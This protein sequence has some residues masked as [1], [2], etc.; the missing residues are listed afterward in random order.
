MHVQGSNS[1]QVVHL[2]YQTPSNSVVIVEDDGTTSSYS[3]Q[4]NVAVK[5]VSPKGQLQ[6]P[7]PD[8]LRSSVN[9]ISLAVGGVIAGIIGLAIAGR[10][11]VFNAHKIAIGDLLAQ[12]EKDIPRSWKTTLT[13]KEIPSFFNPSYFIYYVGEGFRSLKAKVSNQSKENFRMLVDEVV[14]AM[15]AN[16]YR[17]KLPKLINK[18]ED[19]IAIKKEHIV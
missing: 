2:K 4:A 6:I 11:A 7:I 14:R 16:R 5:Q 1:N 18:I 10:R 8:W 13:Q 19:L 15:I 3:S 12:I 17:D 9:L